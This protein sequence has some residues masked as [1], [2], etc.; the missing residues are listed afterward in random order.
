M[1]LFLSAPSPASADG[2]VID[3]GAAYT[4]NPTVNLSISYP[5]NTYSLN[6]YESGG[7][8]YTVGPT[9]TFSFPLTPFTGTHII[10]V[11]ANY[12]Y[13]YSYCCSYGTWGNC[14]G[15]C[16]GYNYYTEQ[17]SSTITLDTTPPS[18]TVSINNGAK[19]TNSPDVTL[20]LNADDPDYTVTSMQLMNLD[21]GWTSPMPYSS[22]VA[23][24]LPSGDGLKQVYAR[25]IDEAGNYSNVVTNTIFLDSTPP[26]SSPSSPISPL[27]GFSLTAIDVPGATWTEAD[28]INSSGQIVGG[29]MDSGGTEHGYMLSFGN[30]STVDYP[31]ASGP[32]APPGTEVRGINDSGQMVGLRC[33]CSYGEANGFIYSSGVFSP[34]PAAPGSLSTGAMGINDTGQ[35]VGGYESSSSPWPISGFLDTRGSFSSLSCF[36]ATGTQA[37]GINHLGQVVGTYYTDTNHGFFYSGGSYSS[38]DYPGAA[39]TLPLGINDAGQIV[40]QYVD[41]GGVT[42]GFILSGGVYTPLDFPN[43]TTTVANGINNAGDIVGYFVDSGGTKHGFSAVPPPISLAGSSYDI[44]GTTTDGSGSGVQQVEVSTDGGSTWNL[45]TGTTN[46][47][48]TWTLPSDG[49]YIIQ[50]RATDNTGNVETPTSGTPVDVDNTPPSS[51]VTA[52]VNGAYLSGG[53]YTITGTASDNLSGVAKVEVSTDGGS[54][55]NL[56]TGTASW[57]YSWAIP[58]DG[59]YTIQ[60]R[61]TDNAGN[62]ENPGAGVS[63]TLDNT[64]PVVSAGPDEITNTTFTQTATASDATSM[65]YSWTKVSGPGTIT[66][67]SPNALETTISASADGAYVIQFTASDAAGISASSTM[68]LTWDTSPPTVSAGADKITNAVFTQTAAASDATSMTYSWSKASGPG[69]ITFGSPNA[70]STTI[71]ASADGAYVIQFTTTDAAGNSASSTMNLTWDTTAPISAITS[72]AGPYVSGVSCTISGTAADTLSGINSV[73]I[74][75][76]GGTTW[77]PVNGTTSWSYTWTLPAD[78]KYVIKTQATDNAGNRETLG[79]GLTLTVDNSNPSSYVTAPAAGDIL[80]GTD[81]IITGT[82]VDSGSGVGKVEVSTDGGATW[83]NAAGTT[84][85]SYTWTLPADGSYTIRSRATANS[86]HVETPGGGINVTVD[87]TTPILTKPTDMTVHPAQYSPNLPEFE[88]VPNTCVR[89]KVWFSGNPYFKKAINFLSDNKG[90]SGTYNPPAAKWNRITSLGSV[91]YWKVEGWTADKQILQSNTLRLVL[92]GGYT[93]LSDIPSVDVSNIPTMECD[94][95]SSAPVFAEFAAEPYFLR[96]FKIKSLVVGSIDT[97]TPNTPAWINITRLGS[98]FYWRFV[99]KLLTG[100]TTYSD[101]K[102]SVVTGGPVIS[103]P[104]NESAVSYP[105]TV[106]WD[107]TGFVKCIVQ[108]NAAA[109]FSGKTILLGVSKTGSLALS[110]KAW[111]KLNAIG[112]KAYIQIIGKTSKNF[113]AYGQP[114]EIN[115]QP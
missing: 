49:N 25:F 9:T 1:V 113:T 37:Y 107:P 108:A 74:S 29:Y 11:V 41:S 98:Q 110:E 44:T 38:I 54:T 47:S 80:Y 45:A 10:Y 81:T 88:W 42:H 97:Y 114:I 59:S 27:K 40:G 84:N 86:G 53:N 14:N 51:A 18:G 85:W 71:S 77:N 34:M 99:G 100:E 96:P 73:Q 57:S 19:Y 68:N 64:A 65:T 92:D 102:T 106:S 94:P 91:I 39:Q 35:I 28:G 101:T 43:A 93:N 70:L 103:E 23:W 69:T 76:D 15:Y 7:A 109:D 30:F 17:L 82:A 78:G 4:N 12:Y 26:A 72:P 32:G 75:T 3:G 22:S 62:V 5:A 90:I 89:F 66:F 21:G 67:G 50:S 79:A 2:V 56:A 6:I 33:A 95:G 112:T 61:A 105:L 60:S 48:Y 46:W 58:S 8:S 24:T 87:N 36:G 63:V 111:S 16:T 83:N 13:T 52:P 20:N 55:W 115:I 31:G 104:A